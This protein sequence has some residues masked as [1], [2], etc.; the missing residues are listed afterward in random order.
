MVT[1]TNNEMIRKR[2]ISNVEPTTKHINSINIYTNSN[3]NGKVKQQL[4]NYNSFSPILSK[5][6]QQLGK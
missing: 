2:I 1:E 5:K 6:R 4:I 3:S